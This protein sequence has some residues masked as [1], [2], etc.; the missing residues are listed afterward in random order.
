MEWKQFE[1]VLNTPE[2]LGAAI[3]GIA[4]LMASLI[5]LTAVILGVRATHERNYREWAWGQIYDLLNEIT[6][7]HIKAH[8]HLSYFKNDL[9]NDVDYSDD[10]YEKTLNLSWTK[11][12]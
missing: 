3:Q 5:A 4:T 9:D 7:I 8:R 10:K 6:V 12:L 1:A 11:L 2:A